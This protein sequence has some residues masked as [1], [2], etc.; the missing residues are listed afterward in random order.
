MGKYC[1]LFISSL[2]RLQLARKRKLQDGCLLKILISCNISY[3]ICISPLGRRLGVGPRINFGRVLHSE[4][5][6][7]ET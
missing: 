2:I 6:N 5:K 1:Q 7:Y 4:R 3:R